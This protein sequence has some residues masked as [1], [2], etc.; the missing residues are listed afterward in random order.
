[1]KLGSDCKSFLGSL[2]MCLNRSKA[3]NCARTWNSV[4]KFSLIF[5]NMVL[6]FDSSSHVA[7]IR[8]S[9]STYNGRELG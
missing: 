1:M 2:A 7:G 9:F 4:F 5:L 6:A 3:L 8:V